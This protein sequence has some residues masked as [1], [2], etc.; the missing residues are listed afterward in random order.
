MS[1]ADAGGLAI[2]DGV[3]IEVGENSRHMAAPGRGGVAG[4]WPQ[5]TDV[6]AIAAVVAEAR[7]SMA[8]IIADAHA[9]RIDCEAR[10]ASIHRQRPARR[11]R[12]RAPIGRPAAAAPVEEH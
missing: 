1:G 5:G 2:R 9:F 11:S 6:A 4:A 7:A 3:D 8:A 12:G 10:L